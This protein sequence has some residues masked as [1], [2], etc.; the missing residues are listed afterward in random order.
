MNRLTSRVLLT[1]GALLLSACAHLNN[2]LDDVKIGMDREQ[3]IRSVPHRGETL[4]QGATEYLLYRVGAS[5]YSLYSDNP[6]SVL[7]LR[8]EGGKVVDKGVVGIIE[9]ARIKRIN[10]NFNLRELQKRRPEE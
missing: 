9:E 4:R 5:F 6:W 1:L 7:F 10:P 3:A 8:L 2:T